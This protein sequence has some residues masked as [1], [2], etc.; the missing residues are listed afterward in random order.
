MLKAIKM[1]DLNSQ[2]KKFMS[3]EFYFM[4]RLYLFKNY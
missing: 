1:E 4:L 2:M 3:L